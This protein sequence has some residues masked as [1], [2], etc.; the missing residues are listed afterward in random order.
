MISKTQLKFMAAQHADPALSPDEK[1][2]LAALLAKTVYREEFE[3][4][5]TALLH[6]AML[7]QAAKINPRTT[8]DRQT[9]RRETT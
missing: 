6:S 3:H 5:A 7:A 9:S 4:P 1:I 8:Y 2:I